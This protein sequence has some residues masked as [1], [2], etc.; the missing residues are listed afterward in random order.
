MESLPLQMNFQLVQ[1][2]LPR[3]EMLGFFFFFFFCL[4]GAD[5]RV[6]P[7]KRQSTEKLMLL[8]CHVG[9]DS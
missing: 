7:Y 5:V 9:E 8:N 1:L 2:V 4:S 3:V 6:E